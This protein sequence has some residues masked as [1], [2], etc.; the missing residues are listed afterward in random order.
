MALGESGSET[1]YPKH[2]IPSHHIDDDMLLSYAAG[3]LRQAASIVV[4]AH[5]SLCPR[6][7]A[8]VR[9]AEAVGGAMLDGIEPEAVS[10]DTSAAFFARLETV[11]EQPSKPAVA[12]VR[13]LFGTPLPQNVLDYLPG[14][15][16]KLHWSWVQPGVKF[17][18][19]FTDKSG[20]RVGLMRAAPGAP[21]TPHSH[22]GDELTLVLSGGYRDGAAGFQRGDVQSVDDNVTHQPLIDEQGECLSLVM[23]EGPVRPTRLIARI[24]RHFTRF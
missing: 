17:A 22:T 9:A 24:F 18:E 14:D 19:M 23:T 16:E 10:P 15:L 20:A 13:A 2:H 21:I 11:K 4:A 1:M 6:C 12:R 5:L 7:R 3:S 8:A